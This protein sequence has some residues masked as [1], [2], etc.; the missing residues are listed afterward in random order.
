MHYKNKFLPM[1]KSKGQLLEKDYRSNINYLTSVDMD[2]E[3]EEFFKELEKI[4]EIDNKKFQPNI[5]EIKNIFRSEDFIT[6]KEEV[7]IKETNFKS[8][9]VSEKKE[10]HIFSNRA[11]IEEKNNFIINL[12]GGKKASI[13]KHSDTPSNQILRDLISKHQKSIINTYEKDNKLNGDTKYDINKKVNPIKL[14]TTD[15]QKFKPYENMYTKATNYIELEAQK[16][17]ILDMINSSKQTVEIGDLFFRIGKKF[18]QYP[19][20]ESSNLNALE[21]FEFSSKIYQKLPNENLRLA[22]I[23][24]NSSILYLKENFNLENALKFISIALEIFKNNLGEFSYDYAE[25]LINEGFILEYLEKENEAKIN[26]EKSLEIFKKIFINIANEKNEESENNEICLVNDITEIVILKSQIRKEIGDC[27]FRLA[28]VYESMNNFHE[29]INNYKFAYTIYE[30]IYKDIFNNFCA[31][32]LYNIGNLYQIEKQFENSIFYFSKTLD[33]YKM[34]EKNT[35]KNNCVKI[36]SSDSV[37][38]MIKI[39]KIYF[40]LNKNNICLEQIEKILWEILYSV[41]LQENSYIVSKNFDIDIAQYGK[42][43]K[44]DDNYIEKLNRENDIN[45]NFKIK[46]FLIYKFLKNFESLEEILKDYSLSFFEIIECLCDVYVNVSDIFH[47]ILATKILIYISPLLEKY[48]M[49]IFQY[50]MFILINTEGNIYEEDIF[51]RIETILQEYIKFFEVDSENINTSENILNLNNNNMNISNFESDL[52]N[53]KVIPS[54]DLINKINSF[55]NISGIQKQNS[56]IYRHNT[57]ENIEIKEEEEKIGEMLSQIG[58]ECSRIGFLKYGVQYFKKSITFYKKNLTNRKLHILSDLENNIAIEY[59]KMG[60]YD[61]CYY[62]FL[63]SLKIKIELYG[64]DSPKLAGNHHNIG[65]ILERLGNYKSAMEHFN[66]NMEIKRKVYGDYNLNMTLSYHNIGIIYQKTGNYEMALEEY[67]K[68]MEIY[69]LNTNNDDITYYTNILLIGE[70]Y[71][72]LK[73]YKKSVTFLDI[74]NQRIDSFELK[75][76]NNIKQYNDTDLV[77]DPIFHELNDIRN[78][79]KMLLGICFS[80]EKNH[81][82]AVKL[83]RYAFNEVSIKNKQYQLYEFYDIALNEMAKSCESIG[84]IDSAFDFYIQTIDYVKDKWS[85]EDIIILHKKKDSL[86]ILIF[87]YNLKNL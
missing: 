5:F 84:D 28:H 23:Y 12:L 36:K 87:L 66:A 54:E 1:K 46:F 51:T 8:H 7:I 17:K 75:I 80:Y 43:F 85:K 55:N 39:A 86:V 63:Q 56:F 16:K 52:T 10:T 29:S 77:N 32:C 3:M 81:K 20:E 45:G 82:N 38:A 68:V 31:S 65:I 58:N 6:E 73:D 42:K 21:C 76:K 22:E 48:L 14:T 78:K 34:M 4:D 70:T 64:V 71:Y 69:K 60:E 53:K 40:E 35:N 74:G 83:L 47:L 18:L 15:D 27:Y 50:I 26:F 33:I 11:S 41:D 59:D 72:L 9:K 19:E 44:N 49:K 13:L 2:L 25:C 57:Q 62:H 61:N 30:Y 37:D 24:K 79:I 67:L